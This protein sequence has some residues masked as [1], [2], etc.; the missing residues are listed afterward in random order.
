M[1]ITSFL[2]NIC[3]NCLIYNFSEIAPIIS[4]FK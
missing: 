2:L 4:Y 3:V 1:T